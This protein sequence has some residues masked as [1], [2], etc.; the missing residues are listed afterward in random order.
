MQYINNIT[1]TDLA[2]FNPIVNF[3]GMY[4]HGHEKIVNRIAA[5]AFPFFADMVARTAVIIP[6]ISIIIPII[7]NAKTYFPILY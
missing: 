7:S 2:N 3:T 4:I 1:L 6:A 5:I